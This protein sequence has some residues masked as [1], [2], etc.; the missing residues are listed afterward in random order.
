MS[1]CAGGIFLWSEYEHS[2][3]GSHD[4]F[5]DGRHQG[6]GPRSSRFLAGLGAGG[7][8]GRCRMVARQAL[9]A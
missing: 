6:F 2:L 4:D 7:G 1:I 8:G 5:A 9:M 3:G